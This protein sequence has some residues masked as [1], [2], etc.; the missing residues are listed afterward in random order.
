MLGHDQKGR[1]GK[2]NSI[3]GRI[4][5]SDIKESLAL[6]RLSVEQDDVMGASAWI[7]S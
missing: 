7:Y 1:D 4:L 2:E 5:S 3:L 6:F